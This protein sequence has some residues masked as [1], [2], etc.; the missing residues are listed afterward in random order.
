LGCLPRA[1]ARSEHGGDDT[2][3]V[4]AGRAA[5]VAL[6]KLE[7]GAGTE[8]WLEHVAVQRCEIVQIAEGDTENG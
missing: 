3:A 4:D 6:D 7:L 8:G 1:R 5:A 2:L